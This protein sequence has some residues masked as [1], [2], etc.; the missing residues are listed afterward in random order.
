MLPDQ[1]ELIILNLLTD[2]MPQVFCEW[3]HVLC[4]HVRRRLSSGL[5]PFPSAFYS[6]YGQL[7]VLSGKHIPCHVFR[8]HGAAVPPSGPPMVW[9][10]MF[11]KQRNYRLY[12]DERK[13]NYIFWCVWIWINYC[14][15]YLRINRFDFIKPEEKYAVCEVENYFNP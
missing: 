14:L 7:Q 2:R 13:S 3:V 11:Q 8:W 1:F 4:H 9:W 5:S 6:I 10:Q 15:I 12:D